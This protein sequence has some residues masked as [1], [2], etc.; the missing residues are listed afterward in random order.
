MNKQ[1][2]S[3]YSRSVQDDL[4]HWRE[5]SAF[6]PDDDDAMREM[7]VFWRELDS[8]GTPSCIGC[9]GFGGACGIG[10]WNAGLQC[11]EVDNNPAPHITHW[12]RFPAVPTPGREVNLDDVF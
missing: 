3:F 6:H 4:G 11:F 12:R 1:L 9:D 7:L 8:D 10:L 2:W 5:L